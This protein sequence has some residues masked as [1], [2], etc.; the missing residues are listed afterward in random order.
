MGRVLFFLVIAA[1][2]AGCMVG[3]DYKRPAIEAPQSFRFEPKEVADTANTQWWIEWRIE[4]RFE[5]R[6]ERRH[7]VVWQWFLRS[8]RELLV[9]R[10]GL[11]RDRYIGRVS[12]DV[13][14]RFLRSRRDARLMR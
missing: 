9:V 12:R 3:P 14:Q 1:C 11:L 7:A 6:F 10:P 8:R 13:R 5:R 4:R 2:L